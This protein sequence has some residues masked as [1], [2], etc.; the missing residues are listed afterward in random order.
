MIRYNRIDDWAFFVSF[1]TNFIAEEILNDVLIFF[2]KTNCPFL[3]F[4]P[5]SKISNKILF[6]F[7]FLPRIYLIL[8][9]LSYINPSDFNKEPLPEE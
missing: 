2:H 1:Q 6:V 5:V 3:D 9:A 8:L 4:R 7:S